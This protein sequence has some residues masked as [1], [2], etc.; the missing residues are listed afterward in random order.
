MLQE[1]GADARWCDRDRDYR[2]HCGTVP[3]RAGLGINQADLLEY[4]V[5]P[6]KRCLCRCG[7]RYSSIDRKSVV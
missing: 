7:R 3:H 2:M 1:G 6:C 4:H 5:D